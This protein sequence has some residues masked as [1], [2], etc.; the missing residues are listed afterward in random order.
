MPQK[1]NNATQQQP[2]NQRGEIQPATT[3]QGGD[4]S[5]QPAR[6]GSGSDT[7]GQPADRRNEAIQTAQ[8]S[9]GADASN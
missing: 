2:T 1:N 8:P 6:Q 9:N 3:G 7:S 5:Q 4:R